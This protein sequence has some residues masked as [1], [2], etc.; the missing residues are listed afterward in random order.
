MSAAGETHTDGGTITV[1]Y[2]SGATVIGSLV[3]S[4]AMT[5]AVGSGGS[6][7]RPYVTITNDA[8][9]ADGTVVNA[10]VLNTPAINLLSLLGGADSGVASQANINFNPKGTGA[11]LTLHF[12][13]ANV[14]SLVFTGA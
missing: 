10:L 5:A 11:T 7:C 8:Q 12:N 9:I 14:A 6:S 13:G 2:N 4:A 1:P 3:L